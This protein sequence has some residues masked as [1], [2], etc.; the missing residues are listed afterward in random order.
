MTSGLELIKQG[1]QS[2]T[3][4]GNN[5]SQPHPFHLRKLL[6]R[7]HHHL[8]SLVGRNREQRLHALRRDA[9]PPDVR[10][11]GRMAVIRLAVMTRTAAAGP[12]V[13]IKESMV[14]C[15]VKHQLLIDV[16]AVRIAATKRA[17]CSS[18]PAANSSN[19]CIRLPDVGGQA[20]NHSGIAAMSSSTHRAGPEPGTTSRCAAATGL[21]GIHP[22]PQ[23]PPHN[24]H[25]TE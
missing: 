4:L 5:S 6:Q 2:Q 7:L 19:P 10:Q 9:L 25:Q 21:C 20:A 8:T 17:C 24:P 1:R 18:V 23:R 3:I 15:G 22:A 13:S 14:T 12:S 11:P 16:R